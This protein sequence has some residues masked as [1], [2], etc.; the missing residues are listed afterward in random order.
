MFAENL[1]LLE[2]ISDL[3]E[4]KMLEFT[5]ENISWKPKNNFGYFMFV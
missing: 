3:L 4:K 5:R 2:D 1:M